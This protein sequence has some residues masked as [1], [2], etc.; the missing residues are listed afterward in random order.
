MPPEYQIDENRRMM[1]AGI[2]LL[3]HMQNDKRTFPLLLQDDEADLEPV[4]EWLLTYSYVEIVDND[5]YEIADKGKEA[6][7]RFNQRY[8]EYLACYDVFC[9]VDL[10]AGEFAFSY[11]D[12]FNNEEQWQAFLEEDRWEDLRIAIA[13]HLNADPIEIVF[14][15]FINEQ[16]FG[17][18]DTGWQF[19]LLLGSVWD[20]IL[21]ICI[22]ALH[23]DDLAYEADGETVPGQAVIGDIYQQ[24][25]ALMEQIG[26]REDLRSGGEQWGSP[27]DDAVDYTRY[28]DPNFESDLSRDN[29]SM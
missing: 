27:V 6:L 12:D 9:A 2:Y 24:G 19:D 10:G 21:T 15:S 14:L 3:E 8:R 4:L 16:R 7:K 26:V 20:N 13:E 1:Y 25:L 29:W 23:V 11:I 18:D 17:R 28:R 5:R 22:R